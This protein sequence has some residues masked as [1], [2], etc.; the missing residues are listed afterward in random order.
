M[1]R[2]GFDIFIKVFWIGVID[3][4]LYEIEVKV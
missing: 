1:G 4:L 3:F 2:L